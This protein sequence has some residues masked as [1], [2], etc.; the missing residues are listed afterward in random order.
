MICKAINMTT[1]HMIAIT[2]MI[3][4]WVIRLKNHTIKFQ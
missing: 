4:I 2:L 1:T 3:V